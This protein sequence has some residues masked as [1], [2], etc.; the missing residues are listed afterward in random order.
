HLKSN[1][2]LHLEKGAT[3]LFSRD[4]QDYL[5][6]VFTRWE[7]MELMNYSP[8]SMPMTS[9]ILPSRAKVR[10]MGMPVRNTGGPGR[11][12]KK[13]DGKKACRIRMRIGILC[14]I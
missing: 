7:G 9:K 6:V 1:V 3:I 13:T 2:N 12:T 4:P 10:W 8:L 11:E 14:T 5:P